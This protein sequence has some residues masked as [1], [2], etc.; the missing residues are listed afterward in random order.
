MKHQRVPA[1]IVRLI[2]AA[3]LAAM[4]LP[5]PQATAAV[6]DV[7]ILIAGGT[8]IDGTGGP[9]QQDS[10]ILVMDGKIVAVGRHLSRPKA[11]RVV[12]GRGK[13][14]I[15][16]LI[17]AHVHLEFPMLPVL[18]PEEERQIV[19]QNPRAFLYNG[20]TTVMDAG[21]LLPWILKLR[22]AQRAGLVLGPRIFSLGTPFTPEGGW[23]SRHGFGVKDADAARARVRAEAAAGVTGLKVMVRDT[24]ANQ[25]GK[26]EMPPQMLK[27]IVD[28]A[29]VTHQKI[30]VHALS[31]SEYH[32]A[33]GFGVST[34][35]HGLQDPVPAGDPLIQELSERHIPVV[36][37]ISLFE[38]F[39]A[40]YPKSGV[41]LDDPIL[42]AS[43][44]SF[45]LDRMRS[46]DSWTRRSKRSSSPPTS[47]PM[48]GPRSTFL[49]FARTSPRC[50]RQG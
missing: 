9:A 32:L 31:L 38:S 21:A 19:D 17:D 24:S 28:E 42:R 45:V 47:N 30:Y 37:T 5:S 4:A 29:H 13:Y 49:S 18:T 10:D 33:V 44:P 16:G 15:P 1:S 11:A 7:P 50:T 40:P 27:A 46:A 26:F 12:D 20:V 14:V 3:A 43:V 8:V 48:P 6:P 23:G 2:A 22:D 25:S 34:M 36:Q 35:M 39:L 41:N